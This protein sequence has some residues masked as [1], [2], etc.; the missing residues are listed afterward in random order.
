MISKKLAH[1]YTSLN[2]KS[3]GYICE[4]LRIIDHEVE[5]SMTKVFGRDVVGTKSGYE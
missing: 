4:V 2:Q 5:T 1:I 3:S